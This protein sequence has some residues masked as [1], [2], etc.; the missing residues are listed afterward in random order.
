[1]SSLRAIF[2]LLPQDSQQVLTTLEVEIRKLQTFSV[3]LGKLMMSSFKRNKTSF[4][5]RSKIELKC[6]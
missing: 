1:M 4:G 2:A 3:I 6:L 5:S